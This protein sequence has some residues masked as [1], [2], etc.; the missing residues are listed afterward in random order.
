MLYTDP[1][2]GLLLWQVVTAGVVGGLFQVRKLLSKVFLRK[3]D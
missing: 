3:R 2:S 1:G